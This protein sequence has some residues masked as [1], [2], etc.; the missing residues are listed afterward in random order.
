M[1]GLGI[2]GLL[3]GYLIRGFWIFTVGLIIDKRMKFWPAMSL[4]WRLVSQRLGPITVI[5][6]ASGLIVVSGV[7]LFCVGVLATLPLAVLVEVALYEQVCGR[8]KV[9]SLPDAAG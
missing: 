9:Q 3:V 1:A 6:L 5:Y 2:I 8:L 7:V 4:S